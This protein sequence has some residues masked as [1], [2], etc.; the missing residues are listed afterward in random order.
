M[1]ESPFRSGGAYVSPIARAA[2]MHRMHPGAQISYDIVSMDEAFPRIAID[3]QGGATHAVRCEIVWPDGRYV[4]AHKEIDMKVKTRTGWGGPRAIT[5]EE[6]QKDETKALG[7]AMRDCGIPQKMDEF[8]AL[9]RWIVALEGTQPLQTERKP[10][11]TA[12]YVTTAVP[13][14]DD[15]PVDADEDTLTPEQMLAEA[16]AL[17][18]PAKRPAIAQRAKTDLGV[19]NVMRAGEHAPTILAWLHDEGG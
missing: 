8:Q 16:L 18:D 12:T 7:R 11:L 5:P 14:E 6:I 10:A 3:Y 19:G 1:T 9:M 17:L 13:D 15:G 4:V 2:L